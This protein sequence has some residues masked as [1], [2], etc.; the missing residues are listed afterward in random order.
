MVMVDRVGADGIGV[1]NLSVISA[2]IAEL[3]VTGRTF[4]L[5]MGTL[6]LASKCIYNVPPTAERS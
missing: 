4:E 5:R 2:T 3:I 1:D 6:R